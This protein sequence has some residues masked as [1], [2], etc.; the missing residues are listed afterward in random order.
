MDGC[1]AVDFPGLKVGQ[2]P[3]YSSFVNISGID[4]K[5]LDSTEYDYIPELGRWLE[6]GFLLAFMLT[7]LGFIKQLICWTTVD[8]ACFVLYLTTLSVGKQSN[9][10]NIWT[11]N[12]WNIL[13]HDQEG[14]VA[15][16]A[17]PRYWKRPIETTLRI[18]ASLSLSFFWNLF[19]FWKVNSCQSFV[20]EKVRMNERQLYW[21]I[22]LEAARVT[23]QNNRG[24]TRRTP[25]LWHSI[26]YFTFEIQNFLERSSQ[27]LS[28]FQQS[29]RD[30]HP[31][32]VNHFCEW[33][34]NNF[35]ICC[36][37]ISWW[38]RRRA[39]LWLWLLSISSCTDGRPFQPP[40]K[41]YSAA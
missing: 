6:L 34:W 12:N 39:T 35:L 36:I 20:R 16:P 31:K 25:Y 3:L 28:S 10:K 9:S 5:S 33:K 24:G 37:K 41:E 38:N 22:H 14:P 18:F 2:I 13:F 11:L 19:P 4:C 15:A 1:L 29:R 40:V 30:N 17:P 27:T 32:L 26:L 7:Q 23:A 8:K 21:H